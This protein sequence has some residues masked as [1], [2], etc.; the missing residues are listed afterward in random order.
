MKKELG[1]G[2]PSYVEAMAKYAI[3]LRQRGQLE[4]A[5]NAESEVVRANSVVDARTFSSRR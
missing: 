3:F 2:H 5:A 1:W 4:A